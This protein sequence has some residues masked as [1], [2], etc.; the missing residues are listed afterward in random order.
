[1]IITIIYP[2]SLDFWLHSDAMFIIGCDYFAASSINRNLPKS[3]LKSTPVSK[4]TAITICQ[5]LHLTLPLATCL[6]NPNMRRKNACFEVR[7][8]KKPFPA[9]SFVRIPRKDYDIYMATPEL[10]FL[11]AASHLDFI[12]LIELGFK[13]CAMY[14]ETD[15]NIF[16]QRSY[17]PYTSASKIQNYLEATYFMKSKFAREAA[18]YILDNSN[19]EAETKIAIMATLSIQQGGFG[20]RVPEMNYSFKLSET[21]RFLYYYKDKNTK[22]IP[23][24][25]KL[26]FAWPDYK[27]A[28]EYNGISSHSSVS[29]Q[30]ADS[31]RI[32]ILQME[33]YK[34]FVLTL[35][36]L[37]NFQKFSIIMDNLRKVLDQSPAEKL[38]KKFRHKR[39][40]LFNRLFANFINTQKTDND[41][42]RFEN[43]SAVTVSTPESHS[44]E[45][46]TATLMPRKP[47]D[48][49]KNP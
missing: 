43:D 20:L 44:S 27:I 40:L 13:L 37:T 30:H 17:T 15:D 41:A 16:H 18:H 14:Q 22:S 4:E 48:S 6:S 38:M 47:L 35:N 26:D 45:D 11:L 49:E 33:G 1:M 19:S 32:N 24:S 28:L 5:D 2:T 42:S 23:S 9:K 12:D 8:F 7:T 46:T 31:N 3:Y 34:I 29:Q 21:E 36:H 10:C 25:I 39:E